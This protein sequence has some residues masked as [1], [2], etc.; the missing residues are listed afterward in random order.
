MAPLRA[1]LPAGAGTSAR[2]DFEALSR[3]VFD[4]EWVAGLVG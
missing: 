1:V 3:A 4:P 2:E